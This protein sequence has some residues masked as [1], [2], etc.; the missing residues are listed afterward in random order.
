MNVTR[1]Q[2]YIQAK[3]RLA[4]E[5]ADRLALQNA[6]TRGELIP[7]EEV[8]AMWIDDVAKVRTKLLALPQKLALSLSGV[9][10]QPQDVQD[11][12]TREIYEALNELSDEFRR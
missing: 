7:R 4:N 10:H 9:A 2:K 6:K 12:L 11:I 5:Q 8:N 1:D 3:T